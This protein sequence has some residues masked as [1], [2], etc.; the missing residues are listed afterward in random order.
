MQ[1]TSKQTDICLDNCHVT[2]IIYLLCPCLYRMLVRSYMQVRHTYSRENVINYKGLRPISI[3]RENPLYFNLTP[4]IPAICSFIHL[5]SICPFFVPSSSASIHFCWQFFLPPKPLHSFFEQMVKWTNGRSV[6]TPFV[7]L[8]VRPFVHFALVHLFVYS[9]AG[10]QLKWV[11]PL[12]ATPLSLR[13]KQ[14]D[15]YQDV[16]KRSKHFGRFVWHVQILSVRIWH[17]V[18]IRTDEIW[19]CQAQRCQ[20]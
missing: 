4:L 11:T 14:Q 5:S 17:L 9:F 13:R 18:Q 12:K 10:I 8:S 6:P 15:L 16:P 20:K 7:H 3:Y 1:F 2:L 19:T